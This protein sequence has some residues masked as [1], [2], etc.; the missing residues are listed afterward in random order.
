MNHINEVNCNRL[1]LLLSDEFYKYNLFSSYQ[2]NQWDWLQFHLR[3]NICWHV[4]WIKTW[5]LNTETLSLCF[6]RKAL[7]IILRL[8]ACIVC[9]C[10]VVRD[11]SVV[12]PIYKTSDTLWTMTTVVN[13][14]DRCR[15]YFLFTS[16]FP[17][18]PHSLFLWMKHYEFQEKRKKV[19]TAALLCVF[20][21]SLFP[22]SGQ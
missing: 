5:K 21:W 1:G 11:D 7:E 18:I 16:P 22:V 19:P 3:F 8:L 13:Q 14:I 10:V 12:K 15:L 6:N 20:K 2:S 17:S 4:Q 9:V